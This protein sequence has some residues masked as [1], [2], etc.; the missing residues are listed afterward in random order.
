MSIV[1]Q[2]EIK[3]VLEIGEENWRQYQEKIKYKI[4]PN[5]YQN[6]TWLYFNTENVLI[7]IESCILVS[8]KKYEITE[9]IHFENFLGWMWMK[10]KTWL[11]KEND[12]CVFKPTALISSNCWQ[13]TTDMNWRENIWRYLTSFRNHWERRTQN[14]KIKLSV[15]IENSRVRMRLF[16]PHWCTS[17]LRHRLHLFFLWYDGIKQAVY[18]CSCITSCLK[19]SV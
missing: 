2:G 10:K 19:E 14:K 5:I 4:K 15:A 12:Y 17:N 16:Y 18:C 13:R 6:D 9:N 7:L 3:P 11:Y 1:A 8:K